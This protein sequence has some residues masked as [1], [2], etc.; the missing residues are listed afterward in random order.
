MDVLI[1]IFVLIILL[2]IAILFKFYNDRQQAIF[3]QSLQEFQKQQYQDIRNIQDNLDQNLYDFEYKL[4][5]S[6]KQD[7]HLLNNTTYD[8]LVTIENQLHS[9]LQQTYEKTNRSFNDLLKQM[10]KIDVT[11]ESLK[12]LAKDINSLQNVLTDK[13]SRGTWGEIELYTLLSNIYG[14]NDHQYMKQYRL[15][16]GNIADAVI[17]A[18]E[19]LGIICIDSKF[20]L[21]HYQIMVNKD[22]SKVER[23]TATKSFK[24]DVKKHIDAIS[25]KYIIDCVTSDQA[26]MFL[27]A[28]AIFAEI[29]AYHP[30]LIEYAYKRRVWLTSPTTLMSTLTVIQM[31]IKNMEKDKYTSIIHEELNKLSLEFARYKERWDK[32]SRSIQAVNKDVENVSITTDKIS[33]KFESINKV[34]FKDAKEI[35]TTKELL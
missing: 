13:K 31:I 22:L 5:N 1:I 27:P 29:N 35:E 3:K 30:D 34:E 20:P 17:F 14:D 23:E 21:E 11:Q 9:S 33:K 10:T 15:S 18:S 28:E 7:M 24:M 16:N 32:L 2:F 26:I 12:T 8:R 6:L 4:V 19:P 25:S